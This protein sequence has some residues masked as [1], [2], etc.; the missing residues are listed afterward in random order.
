MQSFLEEVDCKLQLIAIKCA[1]QR[2]PCLP[3][4][5]NRAIVA[6]QAI[7]LRFLITFLLICVLGFASRLQTVTV[8]QG[9]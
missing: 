6:R 9:K 4:N 8:L 2:K 5:V 7:S 3:W 1:F